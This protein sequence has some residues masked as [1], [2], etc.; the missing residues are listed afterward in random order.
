MPI[1]IVVGIDVGFDGGL[2][3]MTMA[4][5]GMIQ[6]QIMPCIGTKGQGKRALDGKAIVQWF[7]KLAAEFDVQLVCMEAAGAR[8]GQGVCSMF[9]F[10]RVF[11]CLEGILDTLDLP[12][13]TVTP[14]AWKKVVLAGTKKDKTAAM[15]YVRRR[16][17]N[18][19]NRSILYATENSRTYHDGL[20]DALC[21]A[22]Y[23]RRIYTVRTAAVEAA[24][25]GALP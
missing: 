7:R 15:N 10:G 19:G 17:D 14:Q 21:I 2:A 11:G 12:W 9:S 13:Q 18:T 16:L 1:E 3:A 20:A 8:P 22:D 5:D 4:N 25:E 23:A 24:Q 6:A